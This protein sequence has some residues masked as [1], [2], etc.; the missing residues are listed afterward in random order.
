MIGRVT[1]RQTNWSL[2]KINITNEKTIK[3]FKIQIIEMENDDQQ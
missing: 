1:C 3:T 2:K